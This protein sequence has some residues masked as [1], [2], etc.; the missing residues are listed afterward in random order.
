MPQIHLPYLNEDKPFEAVVTIEDVE[1]YEAEE[2]KAA[3]KAKPS[4]YLRARL[5]WLEKVLAQSPG[6]KPGP[7]KLQASQ[8]T[9]AFW[10][11]WR[12]TASGQAP[13]PLE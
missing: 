10:T 3:Q 7:L 6:H 4:A 5:A 8:V 13:D 1:A 9:E 2:A 11:I 12:A